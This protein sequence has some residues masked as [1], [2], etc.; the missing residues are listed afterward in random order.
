MRGLRNSN[1]AYFEA[2]PALPNR[3][4]NEILDKQVNVF[5]ICI[6][7]RLHKT[8]YLTFFIADF[9]SCSNIPSY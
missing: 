8:D 3:I 2:C 9:G 4:N 6:H 7:T 1:N 5:I